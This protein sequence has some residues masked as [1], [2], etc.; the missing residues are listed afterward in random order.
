MFSTS[1]PSSASFEELKMGKLSSIFTARATGQP[2]LLTAGDGD[3]SQAHRSLASD[4]QVEC[5]RHHPIG[6]LNFKVLA[7]RVLL[8]L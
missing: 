7:S 3:H 5:M 1:R 4:I 6:I 2:C 8:F